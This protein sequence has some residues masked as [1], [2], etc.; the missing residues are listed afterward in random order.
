MFRHT[1]IEPQQ[2]MLCGCWVL[3][4]AARPNQSGKGIYYPVRRQT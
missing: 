3:L 1:S 4:V 2:L